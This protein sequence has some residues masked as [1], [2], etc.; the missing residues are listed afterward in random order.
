[1]ESQLTQICKFIDA[2]S[3][4][5]LSQLSSLKDFNIKEETDSPR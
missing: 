5:D 3:D 4:L 1:M 2:V